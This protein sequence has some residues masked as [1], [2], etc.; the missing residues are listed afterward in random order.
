MV[1]W[2]SPFRGTM[3]KGDIGPFENQCLKTGRCGLYLCVICHCKKP[4]KMTIFKFFTFLFFTIT[5]ASCSNTKHVTVSKKQLP[6]LI[7]S[8]YQADQSTVNIRPADSAAAAYQRV[9]RTNFPFVSAIFTRH[10]FPG[11]DLVGKETSNKYFLLVQ[12]SDFE[13]NFQLKVLKSMKQEV[14]KQNA[15]GQNFAFLTDRTELNNG[16]PQIYG[17]QVFMSG[18]TKIKPCIDSINLNQRRKSVGLSTIEE[19][20][21]KCNDIFYQMNPNEKRPTKN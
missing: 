13:P 9:I 1:E 20:I 11:F 19:Y 18:N 7:D 16:R 15:S 17:T 12:H 21:E 2:L 14:D 8:L 6:S 10:G 5:I 3:N 4:L